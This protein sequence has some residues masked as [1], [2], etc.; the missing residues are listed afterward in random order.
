MDKCRSCRKPIMGGYPGGI[1]KSCWDS[2]L[3]DAGQPAPDQASFMTEQGQ[4]QMKTILTNE[5]WNEITT[6]IY[7]ARSLSVRSLCSVSVFLGQNER[8]FRSTRRR[9]VCR[10]CKKKWEEFIGQEVYVA[11]T[12]KGNQVIC[13]QCYTETARPG[14]NCPG[15]VSEALTASIKAVC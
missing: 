12:D 2:L 1:C 10:C 13:R 8:H 5:G 9:R 4:G 14:I 6:K 7:R 11:F 15:E 3:D